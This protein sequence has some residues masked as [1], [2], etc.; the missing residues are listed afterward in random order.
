MAQLEMMDVLDALVD[1]SSEWYGLGLRL[2]L[3]TG[4]LNSIRESR[5]HDA[6]KCMMGMVEKWLEVFP[7][8]GWSDVVKA[9]IAMDKN[10]LALRVA[11]KYFKDGEKLVPSPQPVQSKYVDS[12][13]PR[14]LLL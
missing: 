12:L 6:D 9:L 1:V 3:T 2:G 11:E 4:K 10:G 5:H 7:N 14:L 13:I 8:S